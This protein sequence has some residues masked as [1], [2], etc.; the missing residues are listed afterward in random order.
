M[1]LDSKINKENLISIKELNKYILTLIKQNKKNR[2]LLSLITKKKTKF[3]L[4]FCIYIY[5]KSKNDLMIF[6][7]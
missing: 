7:I 5:L 4:F 1:I 3:I 6:I 2:I